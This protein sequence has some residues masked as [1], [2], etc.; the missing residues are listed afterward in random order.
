MIVAFEPALIVPGL[1]MV[2][3]PPPPVSSRVPELPSIV[4]RS[5]TRKLLVAAPEIAV[6]S[7]IPPALL[8]NVPSPL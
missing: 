5:F 4:P 2:P 7:R 6:H 3:P 8:S 1:A